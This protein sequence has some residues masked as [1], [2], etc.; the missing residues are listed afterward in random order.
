MLIFLCFSLLV[1]S[2]SSDKTAIVW[3]IVSNLP[4]LILLPLVNVPIPAQVN[5]ISKGL[6]KY[7]RFDFIEFNEHGQS[8]ATTI[9]QFIFDFP[10]ESNIIPLH[11]EQMGFASR[12]SLQTAS[13][14]NLLHCAFVAPVFL[15]L[16]IFGLCKIKSRKCGFAFAKLK[17]VFFNNFYVRYNVETFIIYSI[18]YLMAVTETSFYNW[19][20]SL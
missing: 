6:S 7:L 15:L 10:A 1:V 19:M 3:L 13:G 5:E 11:L 16:L 4:L 14:L 20:T 12:N 18:C 2:S 8:L 9:A 17:S